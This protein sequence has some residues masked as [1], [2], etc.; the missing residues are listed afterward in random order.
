MLWT[1]LS[2]LLYI[3]LFCVFIDRMCPKVTASSFYIIWAHEILGTPPLSDRKGNQ[4]VEYFSFQNIKEFE[5]VFE[6]SDT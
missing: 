5:T 3:D 6:F 1:V 4:Y 2:S